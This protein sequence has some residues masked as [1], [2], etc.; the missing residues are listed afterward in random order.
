MIYR[1]EEMNGIIVA[2]LVNHAATV[3]VFLFLFLLFSVF[4]LGGWQ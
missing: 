2:L 3:D 4:A 1:D